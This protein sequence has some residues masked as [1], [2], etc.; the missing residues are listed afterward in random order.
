ML[1]FSFGHRKTEAFVS[2]GIESLILL[3][4][5]FIFCFLRFLLS[6]FVSFEFPLHVLLLYS[7]L[8][9]RE[10]PPKIFLV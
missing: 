3:L 8:A 1:S 5:L 10:I 4:C 7:Q 6:L 2:I 9:R